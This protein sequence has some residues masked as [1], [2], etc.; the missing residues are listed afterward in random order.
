MI[1]ALISVSPQKLAILLTNINSVSCVC[2][3]RSTKNSLYVVTESSTIHYFSDLRRGSWLY[4]NGLTN[5]G[6]S[7]AQSY[8]VDRINFKKGDV[9]LDIGANYGD[10]NLYLRNFNVNLYGFE[11]D[12]RAYKALQ[13]NGYAGLYNIALSD[14]KSTSRFY[15]SH[16][17]ADSSLISSEPD[18]DYLEIETLS[19]NSLSDAFPSIKLLKVEAEGAEPEILRGSTEILH[20][21][22][23]IAIDGSAER[24]FEK[25]TTIEWCTN[26]LLSHGFQL[27]WLNTD[28]LSARALF[29]HI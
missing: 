12:P 18:Q 8:G 16:R 21:I 25:N 2:F 26:F 13:L 19:L 5:R 23:Y 4:K 22:E 11:P 1:S 9:I 17:Q 28:H 27:L 29:K 15:L 24:G 6:I 7:L 10:L 14:K 20:K 3:S